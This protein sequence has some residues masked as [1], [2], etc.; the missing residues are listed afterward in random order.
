MKSVVRLTAS[1]MSGSTAQQRAGW[2]A[3]WLEEV[4][5]RVEK[6]ATA[7]FAVAAD[8]AD[9]ADAVFGAAPWFPIAHGEIGVVQFPAG[10]SNP[11]ITQYHEGTN[12]RGYDDKASW[13]SSFVNWCWTR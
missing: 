13:C 6:C 11:R 3:G 12:I 7:D 1:P 5:A 2:L 9:S 8:D 10:Q 4:R